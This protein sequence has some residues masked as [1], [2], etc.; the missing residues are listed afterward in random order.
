MAFRLRQIIVGKT[1]SRWDDY[2]PYIGAAG[3]AV[4]IVIAGTIGYLAT[5]EPSEPRSDINIIIEAATSTPISVAVRLAATATPTAAPTWTALPTATAEL[6]T[7]PAS[8]PTVAPSATPVVV[9]IV[10]QTAT[11]LPVPLTPTQPPAPT[12][13]PPAQPTPPPPVPPT[14]PAA[15]ALPAAPTPIP[16]DAPF[17]ATVEEVIGGDTLRVRLPDNTVREV[18]LTG[19]DAPELDE[20]FGAEAAQKMR[21][22]VAGGSIA[23]VKDQTENDSDGRLLRYVYVGETFVNAEL[24]R[25]GFAATMPNNVD[26]RHDEELQLLQ[27]QAQSAGAGIWGTCGGPHVKQ[28]L[29]PTSAPSTPAAVATPAAIEPASTAAPRTSPE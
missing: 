28:P 23:M 18:R 20:C 4:L 14:A 17:P 1:G 9:V 24:V 16:P 5:S 6:T 15:T 8:P 3:L 7:A 12:P 22:M 10:E 21:D 13:P 2:L 27:D 19:I 26:S 29:A 11:P 25:E